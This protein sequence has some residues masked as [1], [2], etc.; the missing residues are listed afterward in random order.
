MA[1]SLYISLHHETVAF[2]ARETFSQRASLL[3]VIVIG[4]DSRAAIYAG[5]S[6]KS[7]ALDTVGRICGPPRLDVR[8]GN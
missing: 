3:E 4:T 7:P 1:R 8:D 5:V 6:S 2:R